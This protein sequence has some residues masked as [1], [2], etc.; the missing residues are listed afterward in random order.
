V[1][2]GFTAGGGFAFFHTQKHACSAVRD[3]AES[4]GTKDG[5]F[6]P[7]PRWPII[8]GGSSGEWDTVQLRG[9]TRSTGQR[10]HWQF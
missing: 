4:G 6:I 1:C 7:N 2:L 9:V 5:A 3:D 8:G 10:F